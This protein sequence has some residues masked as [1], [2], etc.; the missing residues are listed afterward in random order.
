MGRKT[1]RLA[2]CATIA[3]A[4]W[5]VDGLIIAN[6]NYGTVGPTNLV[7]LLAGLSQVFMWLGII[8]VLGLVLVYV[9]DLEGTSEDSDSVADT[10]PS[11]HV[12]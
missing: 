1:K 4:F 3:F 2:A 11:A 9:F 10:S 12:G 5:L 6:W 8:S 7:Q